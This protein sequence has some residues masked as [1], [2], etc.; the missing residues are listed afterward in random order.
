VRTPSNLHRSSQLTSSL[1]RHTDGAQSFFPVYEPTQ[2]DL[3]A[4]LQASSDPL[5][6][7]YD[8]T[9]EVRARGAGA[10]QFS[11]DEE[12]RKAQ[13]EALES[14]RRETERRRKEEGVD[15]GGDNGEDNDKEKGKVLTKAEEG[16]KRKL[17]ERRALIEAKRIKV[18]F[19]QSIHFVPL[20]MDDRVGGWASVDVAFTSR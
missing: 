17:D 5:A 15:G 1:L 7:H 19:Q 3:L 9:R 11:L 13:M 14:E 10:Y 4:R 6:T 18:S 2:E 20:D 8:S 16:R 12:E